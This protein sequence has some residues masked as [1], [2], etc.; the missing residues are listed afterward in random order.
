MFVMMADM[1]LLKQMNKRGVPEGTFSLAKKA[2]LRTLITLSL[3]GIQSFHSFGNI[4]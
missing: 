2:L 1:V 4:I 3:I